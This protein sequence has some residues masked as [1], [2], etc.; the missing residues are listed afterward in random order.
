M[1][2]LV[3]LDIDGTLLNNKHELPKENIDSIKRA[4]EKGVLVTLASGRMFN[5]ARFFGKKIGI[6]APIITMNGAFVMDEANN[7]VVV[8]HP[9]KREEITE[10]VKILKEFGIR[11]NIYNVDTMFVA[12]NPERYEIMNR[13][14]PHD[15]RYKIK[16]IDENYTYDDLLKEYGDGLYKCI[17]FPDMSDKTVIKRKVLEKLDLSIVES[18]VSNYEF[19]SK[20][21]NKGEAVLEL[22]EYYG[23]SKD[24]VMTVGDSENDLSMIQAVENSVAMGNALEIIKK[25]AKYITKTND[26]M[27]VSHIIEKVVLNNEF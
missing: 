8:N 15:E 25:N 11:P 14:I 6:N 2:K 9:F 19:T 12:E 18:H 7:K 1:I 26:E 5:S 16:L 20:L 24:E 17:I 21:A 10:L 13:Q 4:V 23:F 22:S 27:G 3:C